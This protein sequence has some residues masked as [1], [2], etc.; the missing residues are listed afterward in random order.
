MIPYELLKHLLCMYTAWGLQNNTNMIPLPVL[1]PSPVWTETHQGLIDP[2]KVNYIHRYWKEIE[3]TCHFVFRHGEKFEG[4]SAMF[5]NTQ[6]KSKGPHAQ[7]V[8]SLS[9]LDAM[10]VSTRDIG[11]VR[12]GTA[13]DA[14]AQVHC[15]FSHWLWK[16][17]IIYLHYFPYGEEMGGG[18]AYCPESHLWAYQS[19]F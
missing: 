11:S 17:L 3:V 14:D 7:I 16:M 6:K 13:D 12:Y 19:G 8:P 10:C 15:S 9:V 4:K 1:P 18:G 5:G 2:N